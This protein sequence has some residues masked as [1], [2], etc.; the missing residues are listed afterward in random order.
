MNR[1]QDKLTHCEERAQAR[2]LF[3]DFTPS[4]RFIF[5]PILPSTQTFAGGWTTQDFSYVWK[6]DCQRIADNMTSILSTASNLDASAST[7]SPLPA[8]SPNPANISSPSTPR[9]LG[10]SVSSEFNFLNQNWSR[11]KNINASRVLGSEIV[12]LYVGK[13][14]QK[15]LSTRSFFAIDAKFSRRLVVAIPQRGE[16]RDVQYIPED[17]PGAASSLI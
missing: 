16:G 4:C 2:P 7:P 15:L 17:Q 13:K 9:H 1:K 6:A 8:N 14:R 12:N 10:L 5:P 11:D 3:P